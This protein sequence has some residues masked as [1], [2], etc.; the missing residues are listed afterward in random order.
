[1]LQEEQVIVMIFFKFLKG[2]DRGFCFKFP[3]DFIYQDW[4]K[5]MEGNKQGREEL[6]RYIYIGLHTYIYRERETDRYRDRQ[7]ERKRERE[8][9]RE[10]L[11]S[12]EFSVGLTF[13]SAP[14]VPYCGTLAAKVEVKWDNSDTMQLKD[15][16]LLKFKVDLC[17]VRCIG[18]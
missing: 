13:F 9:Q 6:E 16:T 18:K 5:K 17:H 12:S 8:T 11:R 1:M 4:L 14:T 7:T 3:V 10:N 15:F 2:S